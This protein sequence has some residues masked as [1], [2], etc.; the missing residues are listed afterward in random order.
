MR[1][2]SLLPGA[3][4]RRLR[5]R[6][7]A[8]AAACLLGLPGQASLA[9]T[10]T[11][12]ERLGGQ[13]VLAS[14]ATELVTTSARDPRTSRTW[15]GVNLANTERQLTAQLCELTGGGCKRDGDSMHD[16][17]AGL[18]ITQQE[19]YTLVEMLRAI[20]VRHGIGIRERNELLALLAP[21]KRDIV[22]Q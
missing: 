14:I 19:F 15:E 8:L 18:K 16:V 7:L 22:E 2:R 6:L 11:L 17:H 10:P 21:M 1:T 20:L 13:D 5:A 12:F 9:A 3:A 4:V